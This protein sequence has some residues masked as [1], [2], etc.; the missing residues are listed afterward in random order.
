MIRKRLILNRTFQ[1]QDKNDILWVGEIPTDDKVYRTKS[2][3][4][5]YRSQLWKN[6]DFCNFHLAREVGREKFLWH[7]PSRRASLQEKGC[8]AFVALLWHLTEQQNFLRRRRRGNIHSPTSDVFYIE[9]VLH[10]RGV[11][12]KCE[13]KFPRTK[14]MKVLTLQQMECFRLFSWTFYKRVFTSLKC[15]LNLCLQSFKY[16]KS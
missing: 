15:Y 2:G 14:I 6:K 13:L 11:K 16:L 12:K 9:K 10:E 8:F 3:N 1:C 5:Q 7:F 4:I